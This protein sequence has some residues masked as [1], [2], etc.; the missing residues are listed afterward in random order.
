[1]QLPKNHP[2]LGLQLRHLVDWAA[3]KK[4]WNEATLF[5]IRCALLG[6]G[7]ELTNYETF[8]EAVLFYLT[9]A[10]GYRAV[11]IRE[12]SCSSSEDTRTGI[13]R[14]DFKD[15]PTFLAYKA[16]QELDRFVFNAPWKGNDHDTA[17]RWLNAALLN[18]AVVDALLHFFR[19]ERN[20]NNSFAIVNHED[21]R[22]VGEPNTPL[23]NFAFALAECLGHFRYRGEYADEKE[24]KL[25]AYLQTKLAAAADLFYG[26]RDFR[27]LRKD[28]V[29]LV[30]EVIAR[31]EE[32]VLCERIYLHG[33]HVQ[34][35]SLEEAAARGSQVALQVIGMK[36]RRAQLE[37]DATLAELEAQQRALD[38]RKKDAQAT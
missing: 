26:L 16:K 10:D 24:K 35:K 37:K 1:V 6:M 19:L 17:P 38:K 29:W 20:Y 28:D 13:G 7:L 15:V 3:W 21:L 33:E 25:R 2:L 36:M 23:H 8:G 5:E 18:H 34:M 31:L 12:P 27:A 22:P 4:A 14:L 9:L 30:P 32:L 11:H